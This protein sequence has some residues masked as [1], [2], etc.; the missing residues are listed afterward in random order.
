MRV[1]DIIGVS[2]A[3]VYTDF[4]ADIGPIVSFLDELGI[5][6]VGCHGKMDPPARHESYMNWMT[7]RVQ[8]IVATKAFGLGI[9]SLILDM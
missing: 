7:E 3:I 6:A 4:I 5:R 9:I 1:S 8:V 2:L